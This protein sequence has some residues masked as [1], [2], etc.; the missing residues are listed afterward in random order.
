M[1][2]Y[3]LI[4]D[5]LEAFRASV[6]WRSDADDLVAEV[7][8]HLYSAVERLEARGA[9]AGPAQGQALERLGD[10][11]LL[12]RGFATTT[13][14]G[15]AVPTP[16]TRTAGLVG[17]WSALPLITF[18]AFGTAAVLSDARSIG[19]GRGSEQVPMLIAWLALIGA[20]ASIPVLMLGVER[21]HGGL[22]APG[23]TGIGLAALGAV[24]TPAVWLFI[25]WGPLLGAGLLIFA[26]AMLRHDLA[27]RVGSVAFGAGMLLGMVLLFALLPLQ[28]GPRSAAYGDHPVAIVAGFWVIVV[29]TT[30]GLFRLGSWLRGEEPA[31]LGHPGQ[32]V[33]A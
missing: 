16:F 9:D 12:A 10:H 15:L 17:I 31:D 13:R 24:L 5:Y 19:F 20:F 21:R 33:S 4:D 23:W 26:V 28:F 22:G 7:A 27:P 25:I 8:D 29:I 6:R 32:A 3:P 30:A 11:K 2:H 1:A 14:G 18:A